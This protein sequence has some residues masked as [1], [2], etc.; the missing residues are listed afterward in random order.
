MNKILYFL[1]IHVLLCSCMEATVSPSGSMDSVIVSEGIED[2]LRSRVT[3]PFSKIAAVLNVDNSEKLKTYVFNVGQA[4]F[5]VLKKEQELVI[6]DAGA[7]SNE[8]IRNNKV[9]V[10]SV[11]EGARVK[12]VFI[13]HPHGDHFSLLLGLINRHKE[14][15][16]NALFFLG[17]NKSDWTQTGFAERKAFYDALAG[18]YVSDDGQNRLACCFLDDPQNNE[19]I[20]GKGIEYIDDVNFKV[21]KPIPLGLHKKDEEN[22]LSSMIRVSFCGQNMLFLG[23]AEGDSLS[24][25]W[26][27]STDLS[28]FVP[29]FPE[30]KDVA[31]KLREYIERYYNSGFNPNDF[32][33]DSF[34][35]EY[36]LAYSKL[37]EQ[38]YCQ[39]IEDLLGK[40]SDDPNISNDSKEHFHQIFC[41]N[42]IGW[43]DSIKTNPQKYLIFVDEALD[44]IVDAVEREITR[45]AQSSD[46]TEQQESQELENDYIAMLRNAGLSYPYRKSDILKVIKENTKKLDFDWNDAFISCFLSDIITHLRNNSNFLPKTRKVVLAEVF[47]GGDARQYM[48]MLMRQLVHTLA[49]R[50]LFKDSQI[51]FIPHHGTQTKNSQNFLGLFAGMDAAHTFIV[52]SS[53]FGKDGLPKASTLEMAPVHPMHPLHYF[54]Y[55]RDFMDEPGQAQLKL[56]SKPI[57]MTGAAPSGVIT[58]MI[59]PKDGNSYLLDLMPESIIRPDKMQWRWI[60]LPK[61]KVE[62]VTLS[63]PDLSQ[64]NEAE[65]SRYYQLKY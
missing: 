19:E 45:R 39:S 26:G 57:Y 58:I 42:F 62:R 3:L 20:L 36:F 30:L 46:T 14:E 35:D 38:G 23:D 29:L 61:A 8:Y 7:Q 63:A 15:F 12:A 51:I 22:K 21:F 56:T 44:Y 53:P 47:K 60:L 33:P 50:K 54:M 11:L 2:L 59:D 49:I 10:V 9:S 65:L 52:S 31:I 34:C 64:I 28:S 4:N 32:P 43:L 13:T 24:R 37:S 1:L 6:I 55:R 17:G 16:T 41:D 25:L 18:R 40:I 48:P 27:T 5:I